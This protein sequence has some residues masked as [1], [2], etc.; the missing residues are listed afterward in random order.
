MNKRLRLAV[1]RSHKYIYAQIIDDQSGRT[2]ASASDQKLP[3]AEAKK[4]KT[5]KAAMVGQILAQKA[6]KKKIKKVWFDRRKYKYHGR[7]KAL[8][9][10]ARKEGLEF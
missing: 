2:L 10:G 5:E 1:F 3:K 6:I 7:I 4:T 8:A 9:D